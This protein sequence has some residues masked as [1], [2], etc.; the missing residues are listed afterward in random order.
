[1]L[2]YEQFL[3][4]G[5][6][7]LPENSFDNFYN[8]IY[9]SVRYLPN[10]NENMSKEKATIKAKKIYDRF[11]TLSFKKWF[12]G[13]KVVTDEKFGGDGTPLMVYHS[14]YSNFST[15]NTPA[16]FGGSNPNSYGGEHYY[17][18]VL[19]LKNPLEMRQSELGHDKWMKLVSDILKDSPRFDYRIEFAEKYADAYGF[20]KL[21]SG[22][23][24][25]DPYRWD[26]VYKYI[27]E[28]GYDGAIYR[29]SDQTINYYFDGYLVM[30]PEQIKIVYKQSMIEDD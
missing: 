29:E 13:S 6:F 7:E 17:Y 19:Q 8:Y 10:G 12:D 25:G 4:E 11:N 2:T 22:E 30:K 1:M 9:Q 28:H 16:F 20:F 14:S 3:L 24:F 15:F 5:L 18:C 26:L 27:N 21:L 23:K